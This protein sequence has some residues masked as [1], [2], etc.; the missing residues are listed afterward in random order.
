[1]TERT[2]DRK[3]VIHRGV[4]MTY[5]KEILEKYI[6]EEEEVRDREGRTGYK[7]L[8]IY[9]VGLPGWFGPEAYE[10]Y[11]TRT[12]ISIRRGYTHDHTSNPIAD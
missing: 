12:T 2:T 8:S 9:T 11:Q 10:V 3:I 4:D 6:D 5:A 1:M 7:N